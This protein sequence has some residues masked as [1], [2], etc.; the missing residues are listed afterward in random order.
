MEKGNTNLA[1]PEAPAEKGKSGAGPVVLVGLALSLTV[2]FW[3]SAFPGIKAGLEVYTPAQIAGLRYLTASL[4]LLVRALI[5][6]LRV[7]SPTHLIWMALLGFMGITLYN[8]VL[9]YGQTGVS[10]GNASFII[11]SAPIWMAL[12]GG[13]WFKE[14]LG[15]AGW[16]GILISFAGVGLIALSSG[17]GLAP[18]LM[19]LVVLIAAVT[20]AH[21]FL[22]QKRILRYYSAPDMTT[23][24]IW[25]GTLFLAPFLPRPGLVLDP[26]NLEATLAVVYMGVFPGALG[27]VAWAYVLSRMPASRAG[28]FLYLIPFVATLMAWFWLGEEPGLISLLGGV[29]VILGVVLVNSWPRAGKKA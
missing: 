7:P 22:A 23:W 17:R 1:E 21:F 14:R 10:A 16:S 9:G 8:V 4:V 24:A 29:V 15:G 19:A 26:A 11:A 12:S 3:A 5:V 27:Y 20:Q 18:N 25:F 2:I 28:S 6:G 13:L